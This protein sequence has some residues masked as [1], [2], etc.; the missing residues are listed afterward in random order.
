MF[1]DRTHTYVFLHQ[2]ITIFFTIMDMKI[3]NMKERLKQLYAK[4]KHQRPRIH[5][6]HFIHFNKCIEN[7]YNETKQFQKKILQLKKKKL[8]HR[9]TIEP[10]FQMI[11]LKTTPPQ[12]KLKRC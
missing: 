6:T 10:I 9:Y 8:L 2:L 12:T 4:A 11:Y 7:R 5:K 1:E 3:Q